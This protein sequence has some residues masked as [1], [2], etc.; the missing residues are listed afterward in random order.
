MNS[1][2]EGLKAARKNVG[3][4]KCWDGYKAKGT[5]MKN[6]KEVPN[7]VKEEEEELEEGKKGLYANIHA[8]RKRGEAPAKPGD[9]DYPTKD[10][11]KKAAKTAKEELDPVGQEDGDV[12]ND[13]DKDSSDKYLMKRR[14]AIGKAISMK[15]EERS[16]W[17]KE[18][19][20]E[21]AKKCNAT[22]EGTDCPEH[23]KECCPTVDEGCGCDGGSKKAKKY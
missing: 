15:K 21:E 23:G 19:G 13:G 12:D 4:D 9:E 7:C 18:M 8:K 10:A 16:D 1:M 5:K 14:K 11:F 22:P 3:A 17:R 6:G 20:L 2:E